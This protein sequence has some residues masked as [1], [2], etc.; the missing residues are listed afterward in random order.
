MESGSQCK[1]S[2][3]NTPGNPIFA[4]TGNKYQRE[5]D[6]VGPDLLS[7]V[8]HYNSGLK[9]WVHNYMM[10][11]QANGT[12][13]IA[14]RPD[15]KSLVF[16]GNGAGGWSSNA[17]VVEKLTRLEPGNAAGAA[18]RLDTAS[19]DVELYD[20]NGLPLS[21]T[22]RG[23]R[24]VRMA[25]SGGLLQ[26]VTDDFGRS[27]SFAY[28][29]LGNKLSETITDTATGQARTWQWTYNA[30]GLVETMTDPK[31]GVWRYGYDNAGNRTC[32]KDP[33]GRETSYSF[34]AAGRVTR[35][36]EPSGLVTRLQL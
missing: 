29:A 30:Q 36:T 14:I 18:W 22:V 7:L 32:V 9:T 11:V 2:T 24:S 1:P 25:Y 26:S 27:L 20:V 16:N 4:G 15:G 5:V 23:G 10:R 17:T 21:I 8:R 34:D 3:P 12:T 13:A 31:G 19:D 6:Y 28:D 33:L 35:Q